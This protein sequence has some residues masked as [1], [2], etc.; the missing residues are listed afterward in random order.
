MRRALKAAR[1][2]ELDVKLASY[3]QPSRMLASLQ[4]V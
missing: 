1:G 4:Q 3:G 2:F